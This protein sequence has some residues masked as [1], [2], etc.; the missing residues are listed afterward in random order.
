MAMTESISVATET[1]TLPKTAVNSYRVY[2]IDAA[3]RRVEHRTL[4]AS[5]DA[6]ACQNALAIQEEAGWPTIEVWG[7]AGQLSCEAVPDSA[8]APEAMDSIEIWGRQIELALG[9]R[10]RARQLR[11]RAATITEPEA[12]RAM[13]GIAANYKD[14]ADDLLRSST[15]PTFYRIYH[16]DAAGQRVAYT[17]F[18]AGG[19]GTA[20]DTALSIQE[21]GGWPDMELWA[22]HGRIPCHET[23]A[24][25]P[26][27]TF[28]RRIGTGYQP[29][30]DQLRAEAVMLRDSEKR[31]A[32]L[33]LAETYERRAKSLRARA[34]ALRTEDLKDYILTPVPS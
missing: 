5:E 27:A 23:K 30:A 24:K 32:M 25:E 6:N 14:M 13:L 3:G 15:S 8:W 33:R 7:N 28:N 12:K 26:N 17:S 20:C 22:S 21:K 16:I 11:D 29:R 1:G 10:P 31:K 34:A 19:D 18:M 9:Y 4:T 2:R